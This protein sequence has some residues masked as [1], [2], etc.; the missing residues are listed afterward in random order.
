MGRV[1]LLLVL[2]GGCGRGGS[3]RLEGHWR[4]VRAEGISP[5]AQSAANAFAVATELDVK[6][7]TIAVSMPKERQAGR[8]KVVKDEKATLVI[9]TD[10]DGPGEPQTFTFVD[11]NTMKW[12]VLDG[13]YIVFARR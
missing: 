10:K 8:Y 6:G 7:D 12:A 1:L 11:E 9:V 5:D 13:K 2:V 3:A 4:G